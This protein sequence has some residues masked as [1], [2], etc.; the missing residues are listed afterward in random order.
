M[1]YRID[2][3]LNISSPFALLGGEEVIEEQLRVS[4]PATAEPVPAERTYFLQLAETAIRHT[5]DVTGRN[6]V[7]ATY[8][9]HVQGLPVRLE[10]PFRASSITAVDYLKDG[11]TTYTSLETSNFGIHGETAPALLFSR[12]T[13]TEPSDRDSDHPFPFR[14][15]IQGLADCERTAD[16]V[17][18]VEDDPNTGEDETAAAIDAVDQVPMAFRQAALLYMSHLYENRQAVAFGNSRPYEIPLAFDHLVKSLL[19]IR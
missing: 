11:E 8:R 6:P 19:R 14:F 3:T 9:V 17:A 16:P 7:A 12:D 15:T 5:A 18:A 10:L 13:F 1:A 4:I 2:K